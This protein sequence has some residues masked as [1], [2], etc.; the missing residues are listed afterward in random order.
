M[1]GKIGIAL[2]LPPLKGGPMG[3]DEPESGAEEESEVKAEDEAFRAAAT[4]LIDAVKTGNVAAVAA[5][6][7]AACEAHYGAE[8]SESE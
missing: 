8:M 4:E 7:R 1:A 2:G 3:D 6:L 5:A